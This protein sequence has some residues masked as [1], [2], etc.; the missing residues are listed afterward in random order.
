M[1]ILVTVSTNWFQPGKP[2]RAESIFRLTLQGEV[3]ISLFVVVDPFVRIDPVQRYR[4]YS[5]TEPHSQDGFGY[6][7]SESARESILPISV[8]MLTDEEPV[9]DKV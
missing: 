5:Y 4:P 2:H 8:P 6:R 3:S 1:I 7:H 9:L